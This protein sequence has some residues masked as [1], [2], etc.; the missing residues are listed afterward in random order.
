MSKS[1]ILAILVV[2]GVAYGVIAE[3]I[4]VLSMPIAI[5]VNLLAEEK[6]KENN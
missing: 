1:T 6:R 5:P 4:D 3:K 2:G